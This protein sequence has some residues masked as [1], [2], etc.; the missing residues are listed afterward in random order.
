MPVI[1]Y[2]PVA[3]VKP[4]DLGIPMI[5]SAIGIGSCVG[6]AG[7]FDKNYPTWMVGPFN[8]GDIA[9]II[10]FAATMGIASYSTNP[11]VKTVSV[12]A[13]VTALMTRIV[14]RVAG[15]MAGRLGV[16]KAA[17]SKQVIVSAP[18]RT[19]VAPSPEYARARKLPRRIAT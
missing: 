3:G 11:T 5:S 15:M 10:I 13:G 4:E 12:L 19:V 9:T 17:P 7:W 18:P 16:R 14:L 1:L 8:S 2:S 6:I